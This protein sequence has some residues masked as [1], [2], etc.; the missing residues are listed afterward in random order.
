MI[1]GPRFLGSS[2]QHPMLRGGVLYVYNTMRHRW[3]TK[4]N[5]NSPTRATEGE[6]PVW[7]GTQPHP[8]H[9]GP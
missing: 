7:R 3:G 4:G 2:R 8:K 9:S 1:L 6:K 5:S